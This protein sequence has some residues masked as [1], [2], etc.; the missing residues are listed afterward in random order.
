MQPFISENKY[1]VLKWLGIER[2]TLEASVLQA[3]CRGCDYCWIRTL[4]A[5]IARNSLASVQ[6]HRAY[7][8]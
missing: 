8:L 2:E 7:A 6:M 3:E 1:V 4:H 5:Y